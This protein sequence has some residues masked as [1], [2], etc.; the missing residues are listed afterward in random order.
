MKYLSPQGIM[1]Y[2][3]QNLIQSIVLLY[4]R[5]TDTL[6]NQ[7]KGIELPRL[8]S[9]SSGLSEL[10]AVISACLWPFL[11]PEVNPHQPHTEELSQQRR[12]TEILFQIGKSHRIKVAII[13]AVL[14]GWK[15]AE[16]QQW[17]SGLVKHNTLLFAVNAVWQ[18]KL[19][20]VGLE[21]WCNLYFS[22]V[23]IQ[24][25]PSFSQICVMPLLP[26]LTGII[27]VANVSVSL[28]HS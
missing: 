4:F 19:Y 11:Y 27:L 18:T 6:L 24:S 12:K 22:H 2:V 5:T 15:N 26:S 13:I 23:P 28:F 8:S 9:T 17:R 10:A 3:S 21:T 1:P 25:A 20:S 7:V 16:E 14:L